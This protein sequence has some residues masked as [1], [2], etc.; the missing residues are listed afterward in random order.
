MWNAS[1]VKSHLGQVACG[2]GLVADRSDGSDGSLGLIPVFSVGFRVSKSVISC[3]IMSIFSPLIPSLS[4]IY[5]NIYISL[6]IYND[7]LNRNLCNSPFL[8]NSNKS[9]QI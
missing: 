4:P 2:L 7:M 6:Y 1:P 5:I 8:V 3:S 9:I